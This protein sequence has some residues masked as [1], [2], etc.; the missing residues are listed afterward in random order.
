MVIDQICLTPEPHKTPH[1]P[2]LAF[3]PSPSYPAV[4]GTLDVVTPG[5]CCHHIND[6]L[7]LPPKSAV[8]ILSSDF[9][10]SGV[11]TLQVSGTFFTILVKIYL[12]SANLPCF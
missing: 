5:S 4:P 3:L 10:V 2:S 12:I 11:E 1:N 9:S 8:I 6:L 7:S